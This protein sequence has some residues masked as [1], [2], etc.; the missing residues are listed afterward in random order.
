MPRFNANLA[1]MAAE[2]FLS[3]MLGQ[4]LGA[5]VVVTGEN[6]AFGQKRRGDCAMLKAWGEAKG[7]RVITVPPVRV[8]D[9][10]CSSSAIRGCLLE[11]K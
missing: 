10:I 5:K 7:V 2:D 11:G 3:Q 8:H 1:S 4:Q 6:F 9:A